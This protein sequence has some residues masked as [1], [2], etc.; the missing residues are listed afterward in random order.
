MSAAGAPSAARLSLES[1][2][3]TAAEHLPLGSCAA[4]GKVPVAPP[5]LAW[6]SSGGEDSGRH[7]GDSGG[8]GSLLGSP[9]LNSGTG[10]A[11]RANEDGAPAAEAAGLVPQ[12]PPLPPLPPLQPPQ[13]QLPSLRE[14]APRLPPVNAPPPKSR[15]EAT[16]VLNGTDQ[17]HCTSLHSHGTEGATLS[18]GQGATAGCGAFAAFEVSE[19][20]GDSAPSRPR[21]ALAGELKESAMLGDSLRVGELLAEGLSVNAP[22]PGGSGEPM[23]ATLLHSVCG[24]PGE[25][26]GRARAG[27]L[28][29]VERL[30]KSRAN[31][32][33]RSSDGCTP[34][35]RA[36]MRKNLGVAK[37]LLER[38]ADAAAVDDQGLTSLKWALILD[39]PRT[40]RL[41]RSSRRYGVRSPLD[42]TVAT[43]AAKR[44]GGRSSDSEE[45]PLGASEGSAQSAAEGSAEGGAKGG[46]EGDEDAVL[47]IDGELDDSDTEV[48][49]DEP[50]ELDST[51]KNAGADGRVSAELVRALLE[52][53]PGGL[54]RLAG[55]PVER[56][57]S[58]GHNKR[59][60]IKTMQPGGR[61][62]LRFADTKER[63][64][65]DNENWALGQSTKSKAAQPGGA[66]GRET[67]LQLAVRMLNHEAAAVLIEE[68]GAQALWLHEA[69]RTGSFELVSTLL[70]GRADPM[71]VN[72]AGDTPM[73]VALQVSGEDPRLLDALREAAR[74]RG[75]HQVETSARDKSSAS[76]WRKG[77][78]ARS[79]ADRKSPTAWG[80][81]G[82]KTSLLSGSQANVSSVATAATPAGR[83]SKVAQVLH[84]LKVIETLQRL[85]KVATP[86]WEEATRVCRVLLAHR[87]F[88]C[89]QLMLLLCGLI[90]VDMWV[91]IDGNEQVLDNILIAIVTA[92]VAELLVQAIGRRSAYL[93]S[94]FF[95]MDLLGAAS[96]LLDISTL[97]WV[98]SLGGGIGGNAV[99]MRAART[100]RLGARAGRFSRLV[101]F[102]RPG[103][104]EEGYHSCSAQAL[105]RL[106]V[107]KTSTRVSCLILV[108]A[109]VLPVFSIFTYPM[110]D[111]S[112]M[113]WTSQ[114][115][116]VLLLWQGNATAPDVQDTIADFRAAYVQR[117]YFP[118][119]M[120]Y[121][122]P[123]QELETLWES[124]NSLRARNQLRIAS[125]SALVYF[126]FSGV[127]QA[128]AAANLGVIALVIV[129][130][131]GLSLV[132]S[133]AVSVLALRPLEQIFS[134]VRHIGFTICGHVES[135]RSSSRWGAAPGDDENHANEEESSAAEI[136]LLEK[137]VKKLAALSEITMRQ[138]LP[139]DVQTLQYLG[140]VQVRTA[141]IDFSLAARK[142]SRM[143][144]PQGS[145]CS[146]TSYSIFIDPGTP[147]HGKLGAEASADPLQ[148][149]R[150]WSYSALTLG[151]EKSC[152]VCTLMLK[153]ASEKVQA[154]N[155]E[156]LTAFVEAAAGAYKGPAYHN[157]T[158]AVDVT[159]VVWL[160]FHRCGRTGRFM[161]ALEEYALLVSAVC[162]DVG[163]PGMNNDFLVKTSSDLAIRYNDTSPLE[164]MHCAKL[165]EILSRAQCSVLAP[166]PS[167]QYKEVRA[168]A[169]GAILHTDNAH[170]VG[171]VKRLQ[172]FGEVHSE[173]L[174]HATELHVHGPQAPSRASGLALLSVGEEAEDTEGAGAAW[175]TRELSDLMWETESRV[176]FR[177][178]ML[179]FADIS[180]PTRPFH[181]CKAWAELVLAEFFA[182]GDLELQHG[183]PVSPLNDREKTNK[184]FSQV[185]FID[186]FVAPL[187][188][189]TVR[190]L[191]PLEEL[192][193]QLIEN[194]KQWVDQWAEKQP[195]EEVQ[196]M[197]AR[198]RNL[199]EKNASL[200]VPQR[201]SSFRTQNTMQS[202]GRE[203]KRSIMLPNLPLSPASANRDKSQA[204]GNAF[205]DA[206]RV[207]SAAEGLAIPNG[208]RSFGFS[209]RRASAAVIPSHH[210]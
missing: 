96:L 1:L 69:V 140:G 50:E 122:L 117:N 10:E 180:N 201:K 121:E 106:L 66:E 109:M 7:R 86:V 179:H 68:G 123:G 103:H 90:I 102:L 128:E 107:S 20:L 70:R 210:Q 82:S 76:V 141:S 64:K 148:A 5:R 178:L 54:D 127:R 188:F 195:D 154:P 41:A 56:V 114:L 3:S 162:H 183:L 97:Q 99:V 2:Y 161:S 42:V 187:V 52:T 172:M 164:N 170:H 74:Q 193:D 202:H 65:D 33:P 157:W 143:V 67:P 15:Q 38:R 167:E 204:S 156:C 159:H 131:V 206:G 91:L 181:I 142:S 95:C 35:I 165:F 47:P 12:L 151:R 192:S 147:A 115:S 155:E 71:G 105:T 124:T 191:A 182:L 73:D 171:M 61:K 36:C 22:Y 110:Q 149:A 83:R 34:L 200:K 173:L 136:A 197:M 146:A 75:S 160:L 177:N 8:S 87:Y 185:S 55:A 158:H 29:V 25:P 49:A 134:R 152:K 72:D 59:P 101:E 169:V 45:G 24:V 92:F 80:D 28:D 153:S 144:T 30:L 43:L 60:S 194:T 88:Q 85:H 209:M 129:A 120:Q 196:K 104:R 63:D 100:A 39:P 137:V 198:L 94:F 113:M 13:L 132:I 17:G 135:I 4:N 125:G 21:A 168:I 27:S 108:L 118:H 150:S 207:R 189:A 112:M 19:G 9:E 31:L 111:W 199:E 174:R 163:H 16:A 126:D 6:D 37:L 175:P 81:R 208:A 44:A 78:S 93:L 26:G 48:L 51:S 53:P 40:S 133:H 145:S 62:S 138:A 11:P 18:R 57:L 119:T 205:G 32:N 58:G 14:T 116:A 79:S 139:D 98:T 176:L 77:E 203:T 89:L 130:M 84:K 186:F 166:L 46:S 190:I 184:P 23:F